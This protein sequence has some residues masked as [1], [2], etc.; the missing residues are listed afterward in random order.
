MIQYLNFLNVCD[1]FMSSF[2]L[3]YLVCIDCIQGNNYLLTEANSFQYALEL[4]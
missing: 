3:I 2:R 4:P 1:A